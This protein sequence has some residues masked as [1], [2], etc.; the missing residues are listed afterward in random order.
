[1]YLYTRRGKEVSSIS[2]L[3]FFTCY[4]FIVLFSAT[5]Q[6]NSA[7]VRFHTLTRLKKIKVNEIIAG[8]F[9]L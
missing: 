2:L 1:M 4:T 8:A 6:L 5:V 7:F 9:Y 3:L